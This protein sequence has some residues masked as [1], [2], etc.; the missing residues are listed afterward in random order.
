MQQP[1]RQWATGNE[2]V[3]RPHSIEMYVGNWLTEIGQSQWGRYAGMSKIHT[4]NG[5]LRSSVQRISIPLRLEYSHIVS[6][7]ITGLANV[8]PI[9][10][11]TI[12]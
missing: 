9:F 2:G 6:D 3:A 12:P 4:A 7:I 1:S 8:G 5:R 10:S 11:D